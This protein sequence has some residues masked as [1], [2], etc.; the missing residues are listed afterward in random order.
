VTILSRCISLAP[1]GSEYDAFLFASIG[2]DKN[3]ML[4]SVATAL[5]R[6]NIDPWL[7]AETLARLPREAAIQRL[8]LLI[9]PLTEE[10][11][12]SEDAGAI[13]AR[14]VTLLERSARVQIQKR[15]KYPL[16]RS[17]GHYYRDAHVGDGH[18]CFYRR[19]LA[20]NDHRRR[21]RAAVTAPRPA[22][23]GLRGC[24]HFK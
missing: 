5:T 10:V 2:E 16:L 17:C 24:R 9:T 22:P 8:N 7:E 18:P 1:L 14:L 15:Q 23:F 13:A 11:A 4:L 6:L 21:K 19:L 12:T 20:T 3:G